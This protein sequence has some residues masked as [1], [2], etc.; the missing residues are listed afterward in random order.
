[1]DKHAHSHNHSLIAP[2]TAH[3]AEAELRDGQRRYRDD[4]RSIVGDKDPDQAKQKKTIPNGTV[5]ASGEAGDKEASSQGHREARFMVVATD[6]ASRSI[7]VGYFADPEDDRE[8]LQEQRWSEGPEEFG[9]EAFTKSFQ[10]LEQGESYH[11]E[12]SVL[13]RHGDDPRIASIRESADHNDGD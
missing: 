9:H 6:I 4:C 8:G 13:H 1:E 12:V 10:C 3:D 11:D 5:E 2:K 7:G